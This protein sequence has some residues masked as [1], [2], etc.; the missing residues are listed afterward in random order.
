MKINKSVVYIEAWILD[1]QDPVFHWFVVLDTAKVRDVSLNEAFEI[2][3]GIYEKY[4]KQLKY[5][6]IRSLRRAAMQKESNS[7]L[8][9]HYKHDPKLAGKLKPMTPEEIRKLVFDPTSE[10]FQMT[11]EI[12]AYLGISD[13][14][15]RYEA[16][17]K[18]P[19]RE[20]TSEELAEIKRQNRPADTWEPP[21]TRQQWEAL[22]NGC[23]GPN[24]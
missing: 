18:L 22:R 23:E 19:A 16:A 12:A 2:V 6:D 11:E 20:F 14:W 4:Y 9:M 10:G 24:D 21:L 15:K 17:K 7:L 5:T 3:N 8:P 1:L 13:A